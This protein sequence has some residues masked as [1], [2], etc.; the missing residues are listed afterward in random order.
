VE[1]RATKSDGFPDD[2]VRV[3]NENARTLK[4]DQFGFEKD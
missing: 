3:V 2:K 4:F 1:I